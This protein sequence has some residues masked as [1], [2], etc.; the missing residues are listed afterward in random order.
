MKKTEKIALITDM[1]LFVSLGFILDFIQGKI[2]NLLPFF[3]NGGSIG[4]SIVA[5]LIF[6]YRHGV[7]GL[8]CGLLTGFLSMLGGIYVSPFATNPFHVILQLGLDYFLA[9][10]S[11]G[12]AGL[13]AKK[14]SKSNKKLLLIII[15]CIVGGLGKYL[16]HFLSGMIYWPSDDYTSQFLYS[17]IYNG[18]YSIPSTILSTLVVVII[19]YKVPFII[20]YKYDDNKIV[21]KSKKYLFLVLSI[22]SII[23]LLVF[24]T[25]FIL[26]ITVYHD[27]E[28]SYGEVFSSNENYLFL[29]V[30]FFL[31]SIVNIIF[32][33]K[34][35]NKR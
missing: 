3:P 20:N 5:T 11:V 7:Y 17:L 18:L 13:F 31:T 1:A 26:S 25:I 35:I 6:S 32:Y 8:L 22:I 34:N 24:L 29:C 30:F 14:I 21:L 16:C 27:L 28:A 23:L 2:G 33:I 15:S 4:I 10:L 9:W 19:Y 12:L